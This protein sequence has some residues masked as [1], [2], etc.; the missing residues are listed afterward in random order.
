MKGKTMRI[1]FET[2]DLNQ[3][4]AEFIYQKNNEPDSYC[5]LCPQTRAEVSEELARILAK[6]EPSLL[7]LRDEGNAVQGV[8][9]LF[10]EPEEKYLEML[11][12]FVRE[13][14]VYEDLFGY[15]HTEYP[16]FHLDAVV[17]KTNRTMFEAYQAQGIHYD[18]EQI[19]MTLEKYTPK[20]VAAAIVRYSPEYEASY[21]AIHDDE[22]L[23]WTA[24]RMLKALDRYDVF[25]AVEN[26]KAVGYIEMTTGFDENEPIQ[27]LVK[28]D[29]RGKGYGRA[30]LQTAIEANFP[31][32]MILDVYANNSPAL[33]LYLS[34]GF[35]EKLREF[36]G[37]MTV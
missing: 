14:S 10:A 11:W 7:V 5:H 15:L 3:E 26:G 37:S 33:N 23:Y 25:L 17:T 31:K 1:H 34:L 19:M 2:G 27:L 36:M 30:L 4:I 13:P 29:C 22:G 35:Q 21:R 12:G 24:E 28:P 9:R 20:P 16:G 6:P 8:F 32:K 18:D